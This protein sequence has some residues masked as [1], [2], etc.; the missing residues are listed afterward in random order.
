MV[1]EESLQEIEYICV[2][3]MYLNQ[4][5]RK[6]IIWM[7][8]Q[9]AVCQRTLRMIWIVQIVRRHQLTL[10]VTLV[11]V[12][13]QLYLTISNVI[14]AH[15]HTLELQIDLASGTMI[16]ICNSF[17]LSSLMTLEMLDNILFGLLYVFIIYTYLY[18]SIL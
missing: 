1:V 6:S 16:N 7:A 8:D 5:Y 14:Y 2:K 10:V 12:Q 9:R 4:F 18:Y 3:L 13:V 15:V 11:V 17:T